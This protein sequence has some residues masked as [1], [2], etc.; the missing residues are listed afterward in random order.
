MSISAPVNFYKILRGARNYFFGKK[1]F[2]MVGGARGV[3]VGGGGMIYCNNKKKNKKITRYKN[4]E[5]ISPV[6]YP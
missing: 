4:P 2:W 5:K 1:F 3:G 6:A